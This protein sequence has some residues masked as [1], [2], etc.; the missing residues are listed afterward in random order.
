MLVCGLPLLPPE[1]SRLPLMLLGF[2]SAPGSCC[3][4]SLSIR[5]FCCPLARPTDDPDVL[6][7][8][9]ER[10]SDLLEVTQ[11]FLNL[12]WVFG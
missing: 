11:Q 1:G 8:K 12:S 6:P 3:R 10:Y 9:P 4:E 7:Q 5:V 2:Q